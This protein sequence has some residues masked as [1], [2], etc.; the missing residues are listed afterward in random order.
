MRY[1]QKVHEINAYGVSALY[2]LWTYS[3]HFDQIWN[4]CVNTERNL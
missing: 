1:L 2:H 4:Q 3:I